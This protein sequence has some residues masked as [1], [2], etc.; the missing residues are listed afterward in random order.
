MKIKCKKEN[1][2]SLVFTDIEFEEFKILICEA[3]EKFTGLKSFYY[4]LASARIR[5]TKST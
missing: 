1:E 5:P 2:V 4:D 3:S